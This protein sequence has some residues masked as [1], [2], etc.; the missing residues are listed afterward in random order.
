[1]QSQHLG[2]PV[3]FIRPSTLIFWSFCAIYLICEFGE[4]IFNRFDEIDSILYQCEW[5][6]LPIEM[7]R[8]LTIILMSIQQPIVIQGFGNISLRRIMFKK[9]STRSINRFFF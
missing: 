2:N 8:L 6:K 5:Y 4:N 7:K 3:E 9:V 1:M